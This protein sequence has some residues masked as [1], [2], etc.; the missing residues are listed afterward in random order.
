[1][2]NHYKEFVKE[3][4]NNAWYSPSRGE[5]ITRN[6][7]AWLKP[8]IGEVW[9]R[10]TGMWKPFET[11]PVTMKW[12]ENGD[13]WFHPV[14]SFLDDRKQTIEN[15]LLTRYVSANF[16]MVRNLNQRG[17]RVSTH[18]GNIS[19]VTAGNLLF[20][21][22]GKLIKY[23]P[24]IVAVRDLEAIAAYDELAKKVKSDAVIR[25]K[26]VEFNLSQLDKKPWFIE[27]PETFLAEIK[28]INPADIETFGQL[29]K[30]ATSRKN[31]NE[32]LP[33]AISR[34]FTRMR[35]KVLI[36]TG[37]IKYSS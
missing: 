23:D 16:E 36:A 32:T 11:P 9:I 14:V 4:S 29:I 17:I 10:N 20:N 5:Q 34:L 26:I 13:V 24:P 33:D 18:N 28:K 12:Y 15:D 19:P 31:K 21:Q 37:A 25:A 27:S 2:K 22:A 30:W 6:F 7:N 35:P 3:I 8:D 1:M